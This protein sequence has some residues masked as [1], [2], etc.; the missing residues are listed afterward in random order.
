MVFKR[1][2]TLV[3]LRVLLLLA[4]VCLEAYVILE[5]AWIASAVTLGA[6]IVIVTFDLIRYVNKTNRDLA[7]FLE[8]IRHHDFTAGFA[9]GQRGASYDAL[10]EG[11]NNIIQEFRS[12]EAEKESHYHYLQTVIEHIGVALICYASGGEV[13]LMNKAAKELLAKPYMKKIAALERVDEKLLKAVQGLRSGERT[14][15]KVL[16]NGE[17]R[18]VAVHATEF[19]LMERAYKLLSLQDIRPELDGREVEA[20]Q[21]LIRVLTHEIMNSITPVSTLSGVMAGL[22]RDEDQ[23]LRPPESFTAE[24]LEDLMTGLDSIESRSRGLLKFVQAYRSLYK[25]PKPV[26]REV[27]VQDMLQRIKTLLYFDLNAQNIRME[28]ELP[29]EELVIQADSD[30]VEQVLINLIK[31]VKEALSDQVDGKITIQATQRKAHEVIL[32]VRDNG[33]GI[34]DE[35]IE[36]IFVPF[37]TTK[38]EGS[39]IGLSLSRQIMRLHKG[40]ISMQTAVGEGTV[41]TLNF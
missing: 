38:Q 21:K 2:R 36:Q 3:V 13:L 33:P 30:L 17:L 39:G 28:L 7:N 24:D 35:H 25:I 40:T 31:N 27:V 22:L 37:F 34:E 1:F 15:V 19:K 20:W 12:L 32:Q 16:V 23:Q 18:Q 5:M 9:S 4:L 11:F 26:F 6:L 41:F 8:S 14:L 10:K 29:R